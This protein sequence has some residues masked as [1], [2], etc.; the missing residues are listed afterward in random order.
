MAGQL[1]ETAAELSQRVR[2]VKMDSDLNPTLASELQVGGLPTL[3]LFDAKGQEVDRVEGA[4][5]KAQLVE[6]IENKL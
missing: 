1:D 6:W 5:M 2:V 4:L 3:V